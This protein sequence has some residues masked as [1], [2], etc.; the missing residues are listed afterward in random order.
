MLH[1]G[2]G[3]KE[4]WA[5]YGLIRAVDE[6]IVAQVIQPVIVVLPQGDTSFWMNHAY[7]GPLWGDYVAWDLV[8]H[9]DATYRTL[10]DP[11]HRAVGGLSMG[12]HGALYLAFTYPDVFLVVGAHSPSLRLE[13]EYPDILGVGEEFARRDPVQLVEA[14]D[15]LEKL[16]IWIDIGEE[17]PWRERVERLHRAL[18]QRGIDHIWRV[19]PGTHN[20]DYWIGNIPTYL[21]FY[22][23]AL[24]VAR[25]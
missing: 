9:V 5:A 4:E 12:G 19:L 22:D 17:D 20:G 10:P 16:R 23:S 14:V 13:G 6:M 8:R 11:E 1:G 2:G 7:G 3:H 18:L 24:G 25:E 21:S 15:G